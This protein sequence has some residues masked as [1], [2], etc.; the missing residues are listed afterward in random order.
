[1][2]KIAPSILAADFTKLGED[3]KSVENA[4]YLHFD[5]MD[6]MFVPNIS[7]GIPVLL[8]VRKI[9]K[10]VLDV[11]LMIDTPARYIKNFI[12]AGADILTLHFEADKPE[13]IKVTIDEIKKLGVKAGLSIKP[14]TDAKVIMPY[15]NLLDLVLVMTVEPG[16]GGQKF[17]PES[18][19]R[20]LDIRE[21]ITQNNLNVDIE[22]DGGINLDNVG[23][24]ISAGVNVIVAGSAIFGA[25]DKTAAIKQ[26][27]NRMT[28]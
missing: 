19:N 20:A 18:L 27:L 23:E 6:G 22:M 25:K 16:F 1:M 11:H 10:M 8:S 14:G 2:I 5:V 21:Y 4:D 7:F 17:M 12:D 26:F 28:P 15:I 13:H 24:V 9:T 3:I